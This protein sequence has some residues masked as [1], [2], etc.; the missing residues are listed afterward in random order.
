MAWVLSSGFMDK[1]YRVLWAFHF[2][3]PHNKDSSI[4]GVY[5]GVSLFWEITI[6]RIDAASP[7]VAATAATPLPPPPQ[8]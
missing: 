2:M 8:P 5:I 7:P 4:L 3:G 6:K 1:G